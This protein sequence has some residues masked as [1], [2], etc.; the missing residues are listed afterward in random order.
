MRV[1]SSC[2]SADAGCFMREISLAESVLAAWSEAPRKAL[3]L[4]GL[5]PAPLE[6]V[7]AEPLNREP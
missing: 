3:A 2:V 4:F 1:I 7:P 6:E 5:D